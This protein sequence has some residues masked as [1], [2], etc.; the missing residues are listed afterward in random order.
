MSIDI[1]PQF[2]YGTASPVR[3]RMHGSVAPMREALPSGLNTQ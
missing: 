2:I 3:H 1:E